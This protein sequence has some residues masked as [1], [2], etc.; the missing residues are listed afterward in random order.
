M[1]GRCGATEAPPAGSNC[2]HQLLIRIQ[3]VKLSLSCPQQYRGQNPRVQFIYITMLDEVLGRVQPLYIVKTRYCEA[4]VLF[5]S[6]LYG[7][8]IHNV[9]KV[10]WNAS[11]PSSSQQYSWPHSYSNMAINANEVFICDFTHVRVMY[12][13][14]F[15]SRDNTNTPSLYTQSVD[16]TNH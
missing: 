6:M 10:D 4:H 5:T 15:G 14:F 16:V 2:T 11:L 3:P 12:L 8:E 7:R 13:L 9:V 1:E